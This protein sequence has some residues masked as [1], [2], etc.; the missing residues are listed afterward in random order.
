MKDYYYLHLSKTSGRF[1]YE[2][3]LRDLMI[4]SKSYKGNIQY[5][6]PETPVSDWTHH[7]WHDLISED[8]YLICSLRDPVEVVISYLMHH[9][10]MTDKKNFINNIND[11]NNLQ[12]KGFI[13]W[14]NNMVDPGVQ[15]KFDKDLILSRLRRINLLIDSK[16]INIKNFNKIKRKIANDTS[17]ENVFYTEKEDS[18][19]FKT[20]GV[21]EFCSSLTEEEISMIKEI[22][23]MDVELYEA[24]KSLFFPI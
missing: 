18:L 16:D 8:T 1:F 20:D 6:Y 12:S 3:T 11:I 14:E 15:V 5:L 21:K 17:M 13:K 19:E 24:A 2:Y 9:N 4:L 10:G 7:G 22:N 23:Y